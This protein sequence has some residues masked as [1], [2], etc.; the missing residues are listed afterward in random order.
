MNDSNYMFIVGQS[1][2]CGR[3]KITLDLY[4][5][6]LSVLTGIELC[7]QWTDRSWLCTG[8]LWSKC[9][10]PD[11]VKVV[12]N[13]WLCPNGHDTIKVKQTLDSGRQC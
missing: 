7:N 11:L 4:L 8:Y 10:L 2:P 13:I 1:F 5:L 12:T 3:P 9:A 6:L